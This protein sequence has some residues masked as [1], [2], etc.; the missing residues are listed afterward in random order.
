MSW[1][2]CK[3][4]KR[5]EPKKQVDPVAVEKA[6]ND[7]NKDN[8]ALIKRH[9][10]YVI[11]F[12][13]IGH[14]YYIIRNSLYGYLAFI[15]VDVLVFVC[16]AIAVFL[17]RYIHKPW[18][19]LLAFVLMLT[20][21]ASSYAY[22]FKSLINPESEGQKL[23]VLE[24]CL[25]I[26]VLEVQ[27]FIITMNQPPLFYIG[28]SVA[29]Y[30]LALPLLWP[31]ENAKDSLPAYFYLSLIVIIHIV[32]RFKSEKDI[33]NI[34]IR[35]AETK[36][37]L[38]Q[39]SSLLQLISSSPVFIVKTP[40]LDK[41]YHEENHFETDQFGNM[42]PQL[43]I[44]SKTK[45]LNR[46]REYELKVF[47]TD[48]QNKTR[49]LTIQKLF[50]FLEQL[51]FTSSSKLQCPQESL[52]HG[53]HSK[54]IQSKERE[55][56]AAIL[57]TSFNQEDVCEIILKVYKQILGYGFITLD[58][59]FRL[60]AVELRESKEGGQGSNSLQ[61]T[62]IF[63]VEFKYT[64][65]DNSIA[66]VI[67]V[68]DFSEKQILSRLEMI[69]KEKETS[70]VA[71]V[72]DMRVPMNAIKEYTKSIRESTKNLTPELLSELDVI[73]AN[74]E[75]L[76]LLIHDIIDNGFMANSKES[77]SR[78]TES[79]AVIFQLQ[80]TGGRLLH[81]HQQHERRQKSIAHQR[82]FGAA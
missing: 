17:L 66:I 34:Y 28:T 65:Y 77:S 63:D 51:K 2:C 15:W 21:P 32:L 40:E 27:T 4:K 16:T 47:A 24:T 68:T 35:K 38:L 23:N 10:I 18:I 81:G 36:S 58:T 43:C 42:D 30:W 31:K 56:L 53:K 67:I 57:K 33:L 54:D 46:F 6:T 19:N 7:F 45:L 9:Y 37:K 59:L 11:F 75:H 72:N 1:R 80:Q 73:E 8:L 41:L 62:C 39:K 60:Q 69:N 61:N 12:Q 52:T 14:F 26:F 3:C 55:M 44:E 74:C 25:N 48:V 20:S 64:F 5:G 78:Q 70:L 82:K 71:V 29:M 76:N 13:L 79:K 49:N 22:Q 50:G